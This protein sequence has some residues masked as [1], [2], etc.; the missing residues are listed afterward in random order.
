VASGY[1]K[2]ITPSH[3]PVFVAERCTQKPSSFVA[4]S[5]HVTLTIQLVVGVAFK[6]DGAVGTPGGGGGGAGVVAHAA[7]EKAE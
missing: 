3:D 1:I 4:L 7:A 6:P 2:P 5:I